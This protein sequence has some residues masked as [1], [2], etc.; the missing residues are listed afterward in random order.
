MDGDEKQIIY[1]AGFEL[2]QSKRRLVRDGK[3]ISLNA[4]AFDLLV[5]LVENA[6]RVV[7]KE[8]ILNAVWENQFVEEANLAVQI[9]QLRK[10][11]GE[12]KDN[13][14]ILVTVPGKGYEFIANIESQSA[15]NSSKN[16]E[17]EPVAGENQPEINR[18]TDFHPASEIK[19]KTKFAV[20]A[21]GISAVIL[22]AT[23]VFI[24]YQ[25]FYKPQELTPINSLAVLP[26]I[27]Q[28]NFTETEYLSDGLAE[29]VTF[30]LSGL[31]DLRVISRN[32]AFRYKGKEVD[33]QMIG[34]ELN[35][36]A[37]LLGR[38]F[39]L[40]DRLTVSAELVSTTDNSLLWGEQFT[41][42]MSDIELLQTDIAQAISQKL[43]LKLSGAD[44]KRLTRHQTENSEAFQFYLLGRYHLNKLTDEGFFK[45]RDYFQMAIDRDPNYALAYA[46]LADAYNRLSGWNALSQHEGFPKAN[47]AALKALEINSQLAEAH[48]ALGTVKLFYEWDWTGAENSFQKSLEINPDNS[49]AHHMYSLYL[50]R[51]GR[52]DESL[53]EI[54][55]AHQLDPLSLE[56][57]STIG[58]ILYFQ[59][60]FEQAAEQY[61][62]M[63]EIEPNSGFTYWSLG[64][65][66]IQQGKN[67]KAIEVYQKSIPLSGESPDEPASL[68]Y[69][70]AKSG[71]RNEAL[72]ILQN[73][74]KRAQ[75]NYI[76]PVTIAFIYIGLGDDDRAFEWL[77]KAYRERDSLLT[78]LKV[79]PLFDNLRT[80][81]RFLQLIQKVGLPQ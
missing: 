73:L 74:I 47:Q 49:D 23:S 45:G 62:K 39:Q 63:L 64:N 36:Q 42:Q 44:E 14:R 70:Y 7:S 61:E 21:Y 56:K 6:G 48:T 41:R 52:F 24:T 50:T 59:R 38:V 33:A 53:A 22:L 11:L 15:E 76:S 37:V 19:P 2:D 32:S 3:P 46:G 1:F 34:K 28:N 78:L 54:K 40:G 8:E 81:P 75:T 25:Y 77:E 35:V 72:K 29:S 60:H 30:S 10:V 66:Y 13:P 67:R 9:S 17:V 5:F 71:N 69:A 80:D 4:K 12:R 79:E 65:V 57:F 58:E 55:R 27:N 43:R 26:F 20:F 68:A 31:P 16:M 18:E 51:M